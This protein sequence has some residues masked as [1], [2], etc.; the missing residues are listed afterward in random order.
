MRRPPPIAIAACVLVAFGSAW[1]GL[2]VLLASSHAAESAAVEARMRARFP[3]QPLSGADMSAGYWGPLVLVSAVQLLALAVLALGLVWAGRRASWAFLGL[4]LFVRPHLGE[5]VL[6]WARPIGFG[7][8]GP[9]VQ[10]GT[11]AGQAPPSMTEVFGLSAVGA[12][13]DLV[14]IALPAV[15][16]VF[17]TRHHPRPAVL[18]WWQVARR[19]ALPVGLIAITSVGYGLVNP[20]GGDGDRTIPVV[21]V[22]CAAGLLA[23]SRLAPILSAPLVTAAAVLAS[24][25]GDIIGYAVPLALLA[26]LGTVA[27]IQGPAIAAA[28]RRVVRRPQPTVTAASA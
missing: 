7:W 15:V 14:A 21:L 27:A 19:L 4:P 8:S 20:N 9:W 16:Y 12:V 24:P 25:A 17:L 28:Y 1:V 23:T 13:V 18:P 26:L 6:S 11:P 3:D 10:A 5:P 22:A 2:Q